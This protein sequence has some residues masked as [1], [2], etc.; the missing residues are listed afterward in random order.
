MSFPS[1]NPTN[2][3]AQII[4]ALSVVV[5]C[6]R[7][8]ERAR[9]FATAL[10]NALGTAHINYELVLVGNYWKGKNDATPHV[11]QELA[12]QNPQITF[13]A[14]AKQKG[15]GMGW[16]ARMGMDTARG[17]AL[18]LVD[19]DGQIPAEDVVTAYQK[20]RAE[21]LDLC[22]A[23]RVAR[24]DGI[25][26]KFISTVYNACVHIL[27]PGVDVRDMNGKPKV[28]ARKAYE[29]M[30]LESNGWF[31]DGEIMIRAHELG[32]RCGSIP[33]VFRRNEHRSSHVRPRM[34]L[35]FVGDILLY[36]LT[37]L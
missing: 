13:A 29:Q 33:I 30:R 22:K 28:L 14:L 7:E 20:L 4:P 19:G 27:F 2:N 8:G 10:K 32:L 34:I 11:V 12:Q 25:V 23:V 24:G 5:L 26:R 37:H 17:E 31:L 3:S 16:D 35:D 6:Y 18:A 1:R 9:D 21:N 36:R 15:Q